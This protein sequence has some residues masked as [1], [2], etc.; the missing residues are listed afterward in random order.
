M[1]R[2]DLKV[3]LDIQELD[4]QMIRLVR[5][6]RERELELQRLCTLR[7]DLKAQV[8]NKENDIIELKK[9]GRLSEVELS[10]LKGKISKLEGQQSSVKKVEEFN[11]LT[12]EISSL[13]R[14]RATKEA[15]L[16]DLIDRQAAEEDLLKSLKATFDSTKQNSQ[17]L[18]KEIRESIVQI[19]AEGTELKKKR[20]A[21]QKHANADIFFVYEK[22]LRNK[23]DRI[24]VPVE[25]R[26]CSGCHILVTAQHE[27]IVRKGEKL[28]FCEHC[29]RIHFW[30][31]HTEVAGEE[32]ASPRRRRR[33]AA[34]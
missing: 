8:G 9:Q 20:D 28:T 14:E 4:I 6:K 5:L 29:S 32:A 34:K 25:N 2:E 7:D 10:E 19:N 33:V 31:D 23:K 11:A 17:D 13:E 12:Q 1:L 3:I 27:N 18:E 24:V 22:L 15:R 16:S 26:C 30:P 21:L